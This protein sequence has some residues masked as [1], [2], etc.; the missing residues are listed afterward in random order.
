LSAHGGGEPE[1]EHE[2]KPDP[3]EDRQQHGMFHKARQEPSDA[4]HHR[5]HNVQRIRA[6]LLDRAA[7]MQWQLDKAAA[8]RDSQLAKSERLS[9]ALQR[10]AQQREALQTE[11][12]KLDIERKKLAEELMLASHLE[13]EDPDAEGTESKEALDHLRAENKRLWQELKA[14]QSDCSMEEELA[15]LNCEL[16]LLNPL[17][18]RFEQDLAEASALG[19][20]LDSRR[21][22]LARGLVSLNG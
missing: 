13:S 3:H 16:S 5:P 6:L 2:L 4:M 18:S 8:D 10:E 19:E 15:T 20:S 9:S 7:A 1:D 12:D 11:L 22:E 17:L 21:R 14:L